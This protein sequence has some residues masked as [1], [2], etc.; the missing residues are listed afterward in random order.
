MIVE[1]TRALIRL[2]K[3]IEPNTILNAGNVVEIATLPAIVL[4]G[5]VAVEKKRL[6]RDPERITAID[7]ENNIAVREVPPRWYDL[8]FSV[9]FSCKSTLELIELMEECSRLAQ[10]SNLL[11]AE[12]DERTRM[13]SWAW[14]TLPSVYNVPNISEV[15][16]G[17]GE[18]VIHDVEAYSGIR[19]NIPLIKVI[20]IDVN[21]EHI[22]IRE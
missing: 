11:K 17:R 5:P 20:D 15:C 21:N 10:R 4:N 8:Q 12:N 6:M 1:T 22:E 9:A 3:T 14:R 19:E 18:L 16:E 7:I 13:Y 2:F